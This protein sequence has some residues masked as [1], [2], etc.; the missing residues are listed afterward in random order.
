MRLWIVLFA[1]LCIDS[2]IS[3]YNF[4]PS[5]FKEALV[6]QGMITDQPGPYLI[7]ISKTIPIQQQGEFINYVSGAYVSISDNQGNSEILTE[8]AP[9]NYYTQSIQGVVGNSYLL[10]IK[11]E[12]GD[13]YESTPETLLPVG[14]FSLQFSFRQ[15]DDPEDPLANQQITSSN[16]FAVTLSGNSL[17]E[18]QNRVWWRT[19]GTYHVMTYPQFQLKPAPVGSGW[20]PDPPFCSGYVVDN[21]SP[22]GIK[23]FGPCTCCDCWIT[24][25]NLTPIISSSKN[26]NNEKITEQKIGFIQA[27]RR[28]MFDKYVFQ[29]EQLSLSEAVYNFWSTVKVQQSNSSNLFQV[30]PPKSTGNIKAQNPNAV[31]VLGYFAASSIKTHSIEVSYLDVP[32]PVLPMDT[33]RWS[34]L[35]KYAYLNGIGYTIT[36][37]KPLFW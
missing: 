15:N 24:E 17:P 16:G 31:A 6:V 23:Y 27:N 26:A 22:G 4:N 14:D 10:T 30:P 34:C 13:I 3:P 36:N 37:K 35:N 9:G 11:T 8:K 33:V 21:R 20:V 5:D 28:T 7:T 18:Q 12:A 1:F 19:S 2:C 25:Y 29:V 32:Y